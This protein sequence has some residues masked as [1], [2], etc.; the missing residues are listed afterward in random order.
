MNLGYEFRSDGNFLVRCTCEDCG[1]VFDVHA[2]SNKPQRELCP[3][4]LHVAIWMIEYKAQS[5]ERDQ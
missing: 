1:E 3:A 5:Q 2:M 4:C